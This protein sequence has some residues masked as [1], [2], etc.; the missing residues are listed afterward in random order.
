MNLRDHNRERFNKRDSF[1][2]EVKQQKREFDRETLA[3]SSY[4]LSLKE[5][6]FK[7]KDIEHNKKI[8]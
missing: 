5:D 8:E 3:R 7:Q 1:Y 2:S 6:I 4:K